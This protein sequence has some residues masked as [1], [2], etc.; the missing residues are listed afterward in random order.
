MKK[1]KVFETFAG[2]GGASFGLKLAKIPHK[3][4]GYSEWDKWAIELFEA[5][6]PGI[7][8]YPEGSGD[9]TKI[10][11]TDLPDFDLF[12][13]GF[14][15]QPFS[16][17]GLGNGELDMRGSLFHD[18]LRIVSHKLPKHILLE[19]VKGFTHK[20][21]R[22]TLDKI[23]TE[24]ESLGYQVFKQVLNTKDYG[25]PQNR[26]RLWIYARLNGSL[27]ADWQID[28]GKIDIGK[29]RI[30][31]FLDVNPEE[32]LWL[33]KSQIARL[34]E[35]HSV[36]LNITEPLCLDIYNKKIRHDGMSITITEPHHNSLRVVYPPNADGF[37]VRKLS[38]TEHYRLMGFPDGM[39]NFAEQSYQQ[40][41][42]RAGNGWDI[43][44]VS[45]IMKRIL[46]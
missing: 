14:P 27:P 39:I 28:P 31:D 17:A 7:P 46:K 40:I 29:I 11:E 20:K 1:I 12:T 23:I 35:K 30:K 33:N 16:S 18:I 36:N 43:N 21:H 44:I 32:H 38:K 13:G 6:H 37:R 34:V 19:N 41:C 25:V 42:K 45:K 4:I 8:L 15:C 9:I 2:Y 3:V 10:H 22:P 24:L 5:N 26:E